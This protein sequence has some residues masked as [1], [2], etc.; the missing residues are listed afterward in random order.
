MNKKPK[1]LTLQKIWDIH[2]DFTVTLS[3][4]SRQLAFASVAICWLF[5]PKET[6]ALH[7]PVLWALIFTILFFIF[8]ITQYAVAAYVHF[9][10]ATNKEKEQRKNEPD[11]GIDLEAECFKD[12]DDDK[13]P[14]LFLKLK[15]GSLLLSY[16]LLFYYYSNILSGCN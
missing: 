3:N 9:K 8:D 16:I 14:Y 5:R 6:L 15:V 12:S 1:K 2:K 10:I 7:G 13:Y 11:K 4:I